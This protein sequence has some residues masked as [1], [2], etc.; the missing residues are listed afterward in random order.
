M[1]VV[2]YDDESIYAFPERG[3]FEDQARLEDEMNQMFKELTEMEGMIK[4]N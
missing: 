1:A 3:V 4:G 2:P